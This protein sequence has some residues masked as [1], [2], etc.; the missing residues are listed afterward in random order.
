VY[1]L[2]RFSSF[3]TTV[4]NR[5][6]VVALAVA[7]L[8][9]WYLSTAEPAPPAAE[10]WL[11]I[12]SQWLGDH[13]R[14]RLGAAI[15]VLVLN[16]NLIQFVLFSLLQRPGRAFIESKT[17]G[18][19]SRV[20]LGALENAL[21]ATAQQ[22]PEISRSKIRVLKLGTHRYR[23]HI[24]YFVRSVNEAGN[25][26]EHLRLVL[27]KRF[28]DIVVLDPRDRVE[29]DLDLAGIDGL[30]RGAA[31]QRV[32]PKPNDVPRDASFKGPVYP[33]DGEA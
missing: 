31:P 9:A 19:Q 12:G 28:S 15:A 26:A 18:G 16:L 30:G 11:E 6:I 33:V 17:A 3:L 1:S 20:A 5:L 8:Q 22:V 13:P 10:Y 4:V 14:I 24:R 29:F 23:V 25:A 21:A 7:V 32:L 27:K 2:W